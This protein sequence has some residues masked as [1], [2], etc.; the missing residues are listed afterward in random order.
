M[1][2]DCPIKRANFEDIFRW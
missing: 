1:S 2:D